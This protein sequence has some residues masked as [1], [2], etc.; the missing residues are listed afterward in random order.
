MTSTAG[1]LSFSTEYLHNALDVSTAQ[2]ALA[3]RTHCTSTLN[4]QAPMAAW[5]TCVCLPLRKTYDTH[6]ISGGR[7]PGRIVTTSTA[8]A[9]SIAATTSAATT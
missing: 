3:Y 8:P 5:D 2:W 9:T 7:S 6:G 1:V 4:A